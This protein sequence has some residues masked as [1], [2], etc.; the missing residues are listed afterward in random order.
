MLPP[1]ISTMR[2]EMES[3]RPVPPFFRVLVLS[4]LLKLFEDLRPVRDRDAGARVGD[5]HA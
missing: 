4:D 5:R 3:P 2:L 1:C